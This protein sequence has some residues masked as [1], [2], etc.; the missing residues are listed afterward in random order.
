MLSH[1]GVKNYKSLKDVELKPNDFMVV[2]GANAAGK[3]NFVDS[4]DFLG[5]CFRD[6]L[7]EAVASKGGYEN[8]AFR[9]ARRAK[10]AIEFAVSCSIERLP[11]NPDEG[12]PFHD[13]TLEYRFSFRASKQTIAAPYKIVDEACDLDYTHDSKHHRLSFDRKKGFNEQPKNGHPIVSSTLKFIDESSRREIP[14][15]QL[16]M[17]SYLSIFPPLAVFRKILSC[18]GVYQISP[19]SVREPGDPSGRKELGRT[20]TNL[21][22]VLQ[23]LQREDADT[24]EELLSHLQGAVATLAEIKTDYVETK[25]LGLFVREEGVGRQWYANDLSDGTL[26]TLA[27]FVALLDSRLRTVAIEEPE[28]GLHP[29]VMKDFIDTCRTQSKK[30]QIILTTHSPVLVSHL[31]PS[32]LFLADRNDGETRIVP[33]TRVDRDVTQ[34]IRDGIMDLGSYWNSGQMSAVPAGPSLWDLSNNGEAD[35]IE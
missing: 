16:A 1:L 23:H 29:W 35:D 20:G 33:A 6:G 3:T 7:V 27:M 14:D 11:F 25:Q 5:R 18:V 8:I 32:E 2:V 17:G 9:R 4:L 28:N 30:K 13:L 19:A 15:D 31:N 26:R 12:L 24:H 10:G 34:I 21:P 22:A